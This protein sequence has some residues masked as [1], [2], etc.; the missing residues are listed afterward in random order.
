[1]SYQSTNEIKSEICKLLL[2]HK[3]SKHFLLKINIFKSISSNNLVFITGW[4]L[5]VYF[6]QFNKNNLEIS[7]LI[8]Y[9]GW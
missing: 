1:V 5:N 9:G 4:F 8:A 3:Q 2:L 7:G 6:F